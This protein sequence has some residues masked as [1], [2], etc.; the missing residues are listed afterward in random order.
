MSK[1]ENYNDL[2]AFLM[3]AREK[4]FTK[5]AKKLSI[6]PP[7]L[8]K[9]IRLLEERLG[10]RL[11]HRTTR[12]ITLTQ[13]GEHLF[14]FSEPS[15]QRLN[16]EL[17]M[18]Q[19]YRNSPAGLVRINAGLTVV[20]TLLL[21]KLQQIRLQYPDIHIE[22]IS[23]NRFINIIEEGFDAGVRLNNDVADNMIAVKI[24]NALKMLLV[25]T[26]DYFQKH[27]FPKTIYELEKY[28]CI[29]YRLSNGELYPWEFQENGKSI[30]ITP[31]SPW[32]F[33][34]DYSTKQAVLA[35]L[36][37]AQLQEDLVQEELNNGR[38]IRIFHEQSQA[39]PALYLYYPHRK[40]SPAL[41]VVIDMLKMT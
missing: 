19:H 9:T 11:F 7:A 23:E 13:A 6:T 31:Y 4:S 21:P 3:V 2:Y 41:R 29:G 10:I 33:N 15:F 35:G 22:L 38:L 20:N 12:R 1:P 32:I 24:S 30:K 36:G 16:H 5:A 18:L 37:I 27:G 34:D 14:R 28:P 26:P 17:E 25:A 39:L 40:V 8:S